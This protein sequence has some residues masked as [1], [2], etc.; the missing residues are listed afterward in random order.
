MN[1]N[2]AILNANAA[3]AATNPRYDASRVI[4][5]P[6]GSELHCKN[7][8]AEAAYRMLQNLSLIHI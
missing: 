6:R 5:A 4:R 1:A 8:L 7:W 2:D 3:T